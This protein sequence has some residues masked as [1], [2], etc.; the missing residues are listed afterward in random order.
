[1]FNHLRIQP[2]VALALRV[3]RVLLAH[4]SKRKRR[5]PG[6]RVER[7]LRNRNADHQIR[8]STH[9]LPAAPALATIRKIGAGYPQ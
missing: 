3:A 4:G 1:M 6:Y 8:P 7:G 2:H 5:R 9:Q